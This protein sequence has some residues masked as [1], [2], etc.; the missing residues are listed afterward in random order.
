MKISSA[1]KFTA[2]A[3]AHQ[4][5]DRA[6]LLRWYDQNRRSLPWRETSDPYAIWISEIMLQQTRVAA[7]IDRYKEF[8]TLFPRVSDLASAS[9]DSILAAWSGLGYYRRAKFMHEAAR[10]IVEKLN[11]QFPATAKELR[12]LPG[13]GRY[14]SAAIASIAFSEAIAVVDGNVERVLARIDDHRYE[15]EAVW[16]RAQQLLDSSRPGDW[17]QAMMELGATICLPQNP[18]CKRCPWKKCC[19]APGRDIGDSKQK[20]RKKAEI[21]GLTQRRSRVYLVQRPPDSP[22]MPSM[23]ELPSASEESGEE[24]FRVRHSITITDFSISVRSVKEPIG[25]G[26][27]IATSELK[28]IALTGLARKVLRLAGLL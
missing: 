5:P 24:L 4:I 10:Q 21:V 23:W 14:T 18:I 8:L 3:R 16:T 22:L 1:K 11:G 20:R 17:N 15:G 9:L 25:K 13:I 2:P 12:A 27:W 26:Q 6:L 19:T 28:G 7:V